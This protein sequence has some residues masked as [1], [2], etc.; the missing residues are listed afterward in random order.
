[1]CPMQLKRKASQ[2][3]SSYT[4]RFHVA[5]KGAIVYI[6][7]VMRDEGGNDSVKHVM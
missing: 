7:L 4:V 3:A 1:M 2:D 5:I 6:H